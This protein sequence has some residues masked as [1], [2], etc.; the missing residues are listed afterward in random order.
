M[1]LGLA[2]YYRDPLVL[3]THHGRSGRRLFC[4]TLCRNATADDGSEP[5]LLRPRSCWPLRWTS[6]S[7]SEVMFLMGLNNGTAGMMQFYATP[8]SRQ[9]PLISAVLSSLT[10]V[11]A[12]PLSQYAL[13]DKRAFASVQVSTGGVTP[14]TPVLAAFPPPPAS[15][16]AHPRCLAY[17]PLD[18]HLAAAR[19]HIWQRPQRRRVLSQSLCVDG[20]KRSL[21]GAV[22]HGQ[23]C[24]A[25]LPCAG[26]RAPARARRPPRL[27]RRHL[28][29][30][31]LQP[32][33][34]RKRSCASRLPLGE[35]GSHLRPGKAGAARRRLF[36]P[37]STILP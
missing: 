31:L 20:T 33:E 5:L 9:P 28:P 29:L 21:A 24:R 19:H 12:I 37:P 13:H 23:R 1:L 18:G 3:L 26:G 14:R 35:G 10:V 34:G 32:G 2:A 6:L 4:C 11:A 7:Q 25:G 17:P 16:A 27:A 15:A 8:P 30:R 22:C 36:P